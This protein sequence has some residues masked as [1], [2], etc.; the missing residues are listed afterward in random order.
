MLR[1]LFQPR[2]RFEAVGR[3]HKIVGHGKNRLTP[4]EAAAMMYAFTRATL[5]KRI[6]NPSDRVRKFVGPSR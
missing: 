2:A 1:R 4:M 3:V 6:K 5:G